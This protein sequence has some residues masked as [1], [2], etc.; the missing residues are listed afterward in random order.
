MWELKEVEGDV[1]ADT[2]DVI[3]IATQDGGV[4]TLRPVAKL[5]DDTVTL[6]FGEGDWAVWNILHL[7]GPDHPMHIHMTE[8]QMLDRK[9]WPVGPGG[10]VPGFDPLTGSTPQPLP[11]PGAGRPV[12]PVTAGMKDTWVVKAGEWVQVL[13]HFGGATG[14]FMYHCHILDHEDHTM[15]RPFIVLPRGIMAFHG[16]HGGGHH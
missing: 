11:V 12:T 5:F 1:P 8:F 10:G 3:R 15:M 7:G 14:S 16:G 2:P 4:T 13:G 6:R 9:Q